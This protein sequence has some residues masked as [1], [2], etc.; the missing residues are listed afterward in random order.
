VGGVL[1][2]LVSNG[3]MSLVGGIRFQA[4][5]AAEGGPEGPEA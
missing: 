5:E 2:A 4:E 1:T 3:I